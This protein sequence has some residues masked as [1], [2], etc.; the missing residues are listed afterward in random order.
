MTYFNEYGI[1]IVDTEFMRL[2]EDV[3]ELVNQFLKKEPDV[4]AFELRAMSQYVSGMVDFAFSSA[5]LRRQRGKRKV[6]KINA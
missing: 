1:P 6:G 3:Y 4:L 5:L 2:S